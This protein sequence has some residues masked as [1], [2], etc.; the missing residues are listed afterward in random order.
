MNNILILI[1][2]IFNVTKKKKEIL[3]PL[4]SVLHQ[5]KKIMGYLEKKINLGMTV[6]KTSKVTSK[7]NLKIINKKIK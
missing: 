5:N 3:E 4:R 6:K 7:Y 2:I 1:I